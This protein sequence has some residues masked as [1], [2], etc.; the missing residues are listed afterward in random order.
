LLLLLRPCCRCCHCSCCPQA[1]VYS[2]SQF[3][4]SFAVLIPQYHC[5]CCCSLC[6]CCHRCCCCHLPGCRVQ[7]QPVHHQLRMGAGLKQDWTQGWLRGSWLF[8]SFRQGFRRMHNRCR[9]PLPCWRK[10][11]CA[12][13]CSRSC[14]WAC[15]VH[16]AH[17]CHCQAALLLLFGFML[18]AHH[19]FG[20]RCQHCCDCLLT[21]LTTALLCLDAMVLSIVCS[22]S[23]WAQPPTLPLPLL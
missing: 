6:C 12:Y 19:A 4:T 15:A 9:A 18:A 16:H 22:R 11:I 3:T 2:F 1:A 20:L 21:P 17:V 8:G 5:C 7:L 10:F 14:C 23:W 13:V